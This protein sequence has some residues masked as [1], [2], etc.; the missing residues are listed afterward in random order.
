MES[1]TWASRLFPQSTGV[2]AALSPIWDEE[3]KAHYIIVPASVIE[4]V[5]SRFSFALIGA[6]AGYKPNIDVVHKWCRWKWG[7]WVDIIAL[8]NSALLFNFSKEEEMVK[9]LNIAP[10]MFGRATLHLKRWK[11]GVSLQ[12]KELP[13]WISLPALPVEFWEDEVL[14]GIATSMGELISME[15]ATKAR[16]RLIRARLCVSMAVGAVLPENIILSSPTGRF[17]QN[18]VPDDHGLVCPR[19]RKVKFQA[20]LCTC[21]TRTE[22]G[23]DRRSNREEERKLQGSNDEIPCPLF[24]GDCNDDETDPS[25]LGLAEALRGGAPSAHMGQSTMAEEER[26]NPKDDAPN[27]EDGESSEWET[28]SEVEEN[29]TD[30]APKMVDGN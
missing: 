25:K 9:A 20:K 24:K 13:I 23:M 5:K 29:V 3:E 12:I 16:S 18:I 26:E 10:W 21:S 30:F 4:K 8:P 1:C 7:C 11:P 6:F 27:K 19:C 2:N 17:V 14:L 22:D 28:S 15:P